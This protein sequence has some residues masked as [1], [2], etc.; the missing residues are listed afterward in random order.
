M[1]NCIKSTGWLFVFSLRI[2]SEVRGKKM[3]SHLTGLL[4]HL[5]I[6]LLMQKNTYKQEGKLLL[7]V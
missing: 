6:Y 2:Y 4:Y 3:L 7:Y 5:T 1:E